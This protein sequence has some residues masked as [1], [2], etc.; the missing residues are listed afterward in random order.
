MNDYSK[1]IVFLV[2]CFV[3]ILFLAF[4]SDYLSFIK[5]IL[6]EPSSVI[7]K[8]LATDAEPYPV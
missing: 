6:I 1:L 2:Y 3:M 4:G 8:D 7:T 5:S